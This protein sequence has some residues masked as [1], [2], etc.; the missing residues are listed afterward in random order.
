MTALLASWAKQTKTNKA[1]LRN[2]LDLHEFAEEHDVKHLLPVNHLLPADVALAHL[3]AKYATMHLYSPDYI[4]QKVWAHSPIITED[5]K[6]P[7]K[8]PFTK[9]VL[10][11]IKRLRN[12][13]APLGVVLGKDVLSYFNSAL[14]PDKN[15]MDLLLITFDYVCTTA[16]CRTGELAPDLSDPEQATSFPTLKDLRLDNTWWEEVPAQSRLNWLTSL[17]QQCKNSACTTPYFQIK[18]TKTK[19]NSTI[20]RQF[21]CTCTIG[22][23]D[24]PI[25]LYLLKTLIARYEIGDSL[26]TSQPLFSYP[27]K[28]RNSLK[29]N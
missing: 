21:I 11:G 29:V 10:K 14:N 20:R 3:A 24:T 19:A 28:A 4:A 2:F 5:L 8:F 26:E 23:R 27:V 25:L 9:L 7:H 16:V 6:L 12:V 22:T 18:L 13:E 1:R 15:Y 17:F